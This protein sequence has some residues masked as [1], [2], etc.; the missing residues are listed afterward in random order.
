MA[1][2]RAART[3]SVMPGPQLRVEFPSLVGCQIRPVHGDRVAGGI[4]E[5]VEKQAQ[6]ASG[7]PETPRG[8][9]DVS[10]PSP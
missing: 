9:D 8:S 4:P 1:P 7:I 3:P 6:A 5:A 10:R 2:A